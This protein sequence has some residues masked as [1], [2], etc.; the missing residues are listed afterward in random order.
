MSQL[1]R[2]AVWGAVFV[3]VSAV[4]AAL[5][6]AYYF[7]VAES[8]SFGYGVGVGLVVFASI[9]LAVSLI[10][11]QKSSRNMALGTGIYVGRLMFAGVTMAVPVLL[12]LLLILPMLGG[13]LGVYVVENLVLLLGARKL[14]SGTGVQES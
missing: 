9:A 6:V 8:L 1:G 7:G 5:V 13:F 3:L 4:P 12:D 10:L 2:Q 14:K 11:N